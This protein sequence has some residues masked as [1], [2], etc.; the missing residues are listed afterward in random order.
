MSRLPDARLDLVSNAVLE[1]LLMAHATIANCVRNCPAS[2][3]ISNVTIPALKAWAEQTTSSDQNPS[4]VPA[5]YGRCWCE[6]RSW[7]HVQ[8]LL[9]RG[10]TLSV[11]WMLRVHARRVAN[12]T[13]P[14]RWLVAGGNAGTCRW[15]ARARPFRRAL[16]EGASA[17]HVR[18]CGDCHPRWQRGDA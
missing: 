17:A 11:W 5:Q 16:R 1:T 6:G 7:C 4:S 18:G 15:R 3:V 10:I 8:R 2:G 13:L 12:A 9:A 14:E